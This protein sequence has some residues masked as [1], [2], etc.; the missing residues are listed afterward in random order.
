MISGGW[1]FENDTL[2][3]PETQLEQID[4]AF[5]NVDKTLKSGGGKGWEQVFRVNSYHTSITP[6]VGQRMAENYKKWMPNH[7]VIWTQIGVK[8]LGAPDMMVEIEVS[9]YDPEGASKA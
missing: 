2:N 6:E 3:F 5:H 8:E 9:A 7:K 1:T 4:Q